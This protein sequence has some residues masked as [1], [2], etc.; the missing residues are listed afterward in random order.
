MY[1]QVVQNLSPVVFDP[2]IKLK[3]EKY[4]FIAAIFCSKIINLVKGCTE[5]IVL[6]RS[7]TRK[8]V[9]QIGAVLKYG[10]VVLVG[11]RRF[12]Q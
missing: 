4:F 9:I 3:Y 5:N 2:N 11:A 6:F 1:I 12:S 7:E 8:S 10:V